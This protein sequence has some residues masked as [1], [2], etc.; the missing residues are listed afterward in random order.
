[1]VPNTSMKLDKT[2]IFRTTLLKY[3]R[4]YGIPIITDTIYGLNSSEMVCKCSAVRVQ[5]LY[6]K[7]KAAPHKNTFLPLNCDITGFIVSIETNNQKQGL[8]FLHIVDVPFHFQQ[9]LYFA[10]IMSICP[11]STDP[12]TR[13]QLSK[14]K[15]MI[16]IFNFQEIEYQTKIIYQYASPPPLYAPLA[17]PYLHCLQPL[18]VT[19]RTLAV[20]NHRHPALRP[21]A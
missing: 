6:Q 18:L 5:R 7:T 3:D 15:E 16:K 12:T 11:K 2:N 1:M 21:P 19:L 13:G 10:A 14:G 20:M 4:F 8:F 9:F 17:S